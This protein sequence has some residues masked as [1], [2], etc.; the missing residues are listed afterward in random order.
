M[1]IQN[2]SPSAKTQAHMYTEE[3]TKHTRAQTFVS[4][5]LYKHT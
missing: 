5:L 2:I 4:N 1:C 3:F